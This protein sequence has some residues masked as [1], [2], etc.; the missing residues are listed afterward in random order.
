[1]GNQTRWCKRVWYNKSNNDNEEREDT[2]SYD[3]DDDDDDINKNYNN[4]NDDNTIIITI[5]I[6]T[7][8]TAT[9]ETTIVLIYQYHQCHYYDDVMVSTLYLVLRLR[10][11]CSLSFVLVSCWHISFQTLTI[12]VLYFNQNCS[13]WVLPHNV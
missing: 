5:I 4:S 13:K 9:A 1:M 2:D 12:C 6:T 8:I 11:G 7:I 3:Y 10:G